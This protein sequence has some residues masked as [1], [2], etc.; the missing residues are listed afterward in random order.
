ML[1]ITPGLDEIYVL[2]DDI[3]FVGYDESEG[4]VH[5]NLRNLANRLKEC[6]VKTIK[7]KVNLCKEGIKFSGHILTKDG[8]LS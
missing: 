1:E 7:G 3:L 2:A 4:D 5:K 6:N 8:V